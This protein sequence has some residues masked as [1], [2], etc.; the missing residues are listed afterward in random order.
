MS[1]MIM[2]NTHRPIAVSMV[3]G[4]VRKCGEVVDARR[5]SGMA[6]NSSENR[7]FKIHDQDPK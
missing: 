1:W 4:R 6:D 3:A 7:F 2:I 5:S